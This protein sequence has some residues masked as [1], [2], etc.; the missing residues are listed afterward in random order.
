MIKEYKNQA[1]VINLNGKTMV[2]K[3]NLIIQ[4]VGEMGKLIVNNQMC[5][6]YSNQLVKVML[7]TKTKAYS[8]KGENIE[9]TVQKGLG[10]KDTTFIIPLEELI[11]VK[12]FK[13]EVE[14]AFNLFLQSK[15]IFKLQGTHFSFNK[16]E[17]QA[18]L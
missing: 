18:N 16:L 15:Q 6:I 2:E 11:I 8:Y 13:E 12:G 10:M 1:H 4:F 9:L 7:N 5:T 3:E 17:E 14:R